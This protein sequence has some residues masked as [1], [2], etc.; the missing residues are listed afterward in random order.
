MR[1]VY[2]RFGLS[3][4]GDAER[5]E[6]GVEAG[7]LRL[8]GG[9][10]EEV[11]VG[12]LAEFRV[13]LRGWAAHDGEDLFDAGIEEAFAQ[14]ALSYH[15]GCAE[16]EYVHAVHLTVGVFRGTRGVIGRDVP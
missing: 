14:D 5:E 4:G 6:A 8:D 15:A 2:S 7:E 12:Q 9:V 3:D 1:W 13:L 10:V 16:E 11:F